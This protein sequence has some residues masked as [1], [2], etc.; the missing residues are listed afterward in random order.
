MP[1]EPLASHKQL[2]GCIPN[3]AVPWALLRSKQGGSQAATARPDPKP[4]A[5]LQPGDDADRT[6]VALPE[7]PLSAA[8][9]FARLIRM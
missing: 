4:E 6:Q 7:S 5:S 2:P 9:S 3:P 8:S 1:A